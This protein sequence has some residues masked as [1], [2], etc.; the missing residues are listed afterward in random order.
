M[1]QTAA[2]S[3]T[4]SPSEWVP[5]LRA[6]T[7]GSLSVVWD[8]VPAAEIDG[9]R[10]ELE[11][12]LEALRSARPAL[13]G[14]SPSRGWWGSLRIPRELAAAGWRVV[15]RD[16]AEEVV[17]AGRDVS[18]WTGHLRVHWRYAPRLFALRP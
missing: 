14:L 11:I 15:L 9:E 4:A 18:P 2:R 6:I 17:A 13:R 10:R 3:G 16:G 7:G 5:W 12:Q 1:G 8:G